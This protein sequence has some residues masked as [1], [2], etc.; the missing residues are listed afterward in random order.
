[1]LT[2]ATV[3]TVSTS[4]DLYCIVMA[5][6]LSVRRGADRMCHSTLPLLRLNAEWLGAS[7]ERPAAAAVGDDRQDGGGEERTVE[8]QRHRIARCR[9][10]ARAGAGRSDT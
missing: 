9:Q 4:R 3:A 7:I 6:T 8:Q 5:M 1:M 10:R 2:K